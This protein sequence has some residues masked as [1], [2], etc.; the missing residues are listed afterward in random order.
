ML[1]FLH[2]NESGANSA[3][4]SGNCMLGFLHSNESGANSAD[5]SGN[6]LNDGTIKNWNSKISGADIVDRIVS[7]PNVSFSNLNSPQNLDQSEDSNSTND[8]ADDSYDD[9]L[10]SHGTLD[11]SLK[12]VVCASRG[13]TPMKRP[14]PC[15][16][17]Q[18]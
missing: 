16:E 15:S 14:P 18:I 13:I 12:V 4:P 10:F 8:L 9:F 2:S 3:D 6:P 11:V 1:G 5:P 17:E 7:T